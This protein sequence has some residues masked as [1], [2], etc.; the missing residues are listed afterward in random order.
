MKHPTKDIEK[1]VA[2]VGCKFTTKELILGLERHGFIIDHCVT[3]GPDKAEEQKVAGYYD[4]SE[5]LRSNSIPYTVA[6]RYDLRSEEDEKS[7]LS[8]GMD[9]LFVIGWERLIPEWWLKKLSIGA[10]GMHGSSRPLPHGRGRSPLNWSLIQNKNIFYTHM[11]KYSP[12]IDDGPIVDFQ[13]FDITPFDDIMTLHF[14]NT[15]AMIK[16]GV[17]NL[18]ALIDGTAT[19][20]P[21][22]KDD[23]ATYYPKRVAEDG[24]IYWTD[25]TLGI[26]NL[27][28]AV[29][30]PYPGAFTYLDDNKDLKVFI[31]QAFPFDTKLK[32]DDGL[33]G[34]ILEVFDN[35]MFVVKTADS[36][37]LV[38][39]SEGHDFTI[40]DIGRRFGHLNMSRKKWQD[41]PE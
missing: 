4:L 41:L 12:G 11:I 16:L 5:F 25:N 26:Y 40:A 6:A 23:T 20:T 36:T 19:S 35:G 17:K 21:Q 30:K 29:T 10:F 31:W 34:E 39:E 14:K 22:P 24:I 28:R 8:L 15:L 1:K 27:V 7:L 37:L 32:W 33:P 2:V 18:P 3:I 38:K 13:K 9:M